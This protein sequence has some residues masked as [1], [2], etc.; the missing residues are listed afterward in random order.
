L[1]YALSLQI[2]LNWGWVC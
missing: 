2:H 1:F